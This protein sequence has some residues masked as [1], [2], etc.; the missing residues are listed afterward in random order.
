MSFHYR[1][2][3]R[4]SL[5]TILTHEEANGEVPEGRRATTIVPPVLENLSISTPENIVTKPT[6]QH[7]MK[8]NS[9]QPDKSSD[10]TN[11]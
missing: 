10:Q 4:I 3:Q 7:V 1:A 8:P 11:T 9:V 6:V 2:V 5:P